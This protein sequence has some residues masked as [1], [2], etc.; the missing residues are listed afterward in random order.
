MQESYIKK[1][2]MIIFALFYFITPLDALT[3]Q[4]AEENI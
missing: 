4:E 2:I 1:Y 3:K